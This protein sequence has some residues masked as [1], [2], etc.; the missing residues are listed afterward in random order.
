M[1]A[2]TKKTV[3]LL[4]ERAKTERDQ[5]SLKQT[6]SEFIEKFRKYKAMKSDLDPKPPQTVGG[7]RR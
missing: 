2:T 4:R 7:V 5:P 6:F 3:D 1:T